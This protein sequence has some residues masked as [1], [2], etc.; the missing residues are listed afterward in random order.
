MTMKSK[1]KRT[2]AIM[3]IGLALTLPLQAGC[4]HLGESRPQQ[5]WEKADAPEL[6]ATNWHM[7][8]HLQ[9]NKVRRALRIADVVLVNKID[10]ATDEQVESFL[11]EYNLLSIQNLTIHEGV[12]GHYLQIALSNRYPSALRSVA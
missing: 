3:V 6:H 5:L 9:R 7:I 8:G 10:S 4:S 11:R 12:P 2:L 1:T